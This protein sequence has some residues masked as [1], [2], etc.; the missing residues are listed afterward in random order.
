MSKRA[1]DAAD[2]APARK[3]QADPLLKLLVPDYVAGALIGKAGCVMNELRTTYGGNIRVSAAKEFYPGTTERVVV[4]TGMTENISQLNRHVMQKVEDP[5]R[6]NSLKALY[7]NENR[8][9]QAK[10]VLTNQAAGLLIG[11]GGET[12]KTIQTESKAFLSIAATNE[13][14]VP[15]ERILTITGLTEQRQ[16][17]FNRIIDIIATEPSNM[18]NTVLRYHDNGGAGR[19][20]PMGE[21]AI[22]DR[23]ASKIHASI[24][25]G[26]KKGGK[27]EAQVQV[28]VTIPQE[29]VGGILGKSGIVIKDLVH[30]SGGAKFKFDEKTAEVV[31][32]R[33]LTISGSMEQAYDGY[34]LLNERVEQLQ[35]EQEQKQPSSQGL[36]QGLSPQQ[37]P[38]YPQQAYNSW[39]GQKPGYPTDQFGFPS[40]Q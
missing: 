13:G 36:T 18:G 19:T 8:A 12:I 14:P 27:L 20:G 2:E 25:G 23:V 33:I 37:Q 28:T 34:N 17:A 7:M 32:S 26:I 16:E 5:G 4:L 15:G 21:R 35:A 6:D 24:Y 29:Y 30:R 10:V 3:L 9:Q 38:G 31:E 40:Y 39:P 22:V 1:T 11:K